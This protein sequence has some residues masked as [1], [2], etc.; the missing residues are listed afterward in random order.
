M[1]TVLKTMISTLRLLFSRQDVTEMYPDP[2]AK[3]LLPKRARGILSLDT[4]KCTLCGKCVK[5][6]PSNT[7]SINKNNLSLKINYTY[8]M[9]CTYCSNA[10]PEDALV[11]SKEFESATNDQELF[12]HEFN[13]INVRNIKKE[14]L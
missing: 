5:M 11:F 9:S 7:I 2:V 6:C 8:C 12:I 3:P 13:I 4:Y 14:T 1:R 10:C